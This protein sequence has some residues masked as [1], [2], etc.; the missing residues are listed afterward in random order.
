[1]RAL[2]ILVCLL[3]GAVAAYYGQPFVH[4]NSD[5]LLI[6]ITVMTVFA[7]FLV[8]IIA[9]VG[10]PSLIPEGSWRV[11]ENRRESIE[12]RL[13][14][15]LWLFVLYLIAIGLLFVGALLNKAPDSVV[16]EAWKMWIERLYLFFGTSSFLLTF[17][18]PT[19]LWKFQLA[20]IDAEI[21]RRRKKSGIKDD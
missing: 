14:R 5:A 4:D 20:R 18:L 12:N 13:I 8:A 7:G 11:A 3:G 2:L 16:S 10:D 17:G 21:Q 1:M 6:I 9:I 19:A 15:H